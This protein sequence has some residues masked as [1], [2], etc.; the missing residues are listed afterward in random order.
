MFIQNKKT[1]SNTN[2]V[3]TLFKKTK[4]TLTSKPTGRSQA[5]ETE[6]VRTTINQPEPWRL[7]SDIGPVFWLKQV[8]I[9]NVSRAAARTAGR[10][11]KRDA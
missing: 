2:S 3:D 5:Q 8:N 9:K 11:G 6:T 4:K 1:M 10:S 7:C